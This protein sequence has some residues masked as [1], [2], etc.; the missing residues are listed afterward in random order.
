V[1]CKPLGLGT[2]SEFNDAQT[3]ADNKE[4]STAEKWLET[5]IAD[6]SN[7]LR[8]PVSL[9]DVCET[10]YMLLCCEMYEFAMASVT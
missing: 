4:Y 8:L 5:S 7:M 6:L 10:H 2:I 1:F 3:S 9:L